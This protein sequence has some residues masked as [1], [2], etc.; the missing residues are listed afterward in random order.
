MN[1]ENLSVRW[2]KAPGSQTQW[3]FQLLCVLLRRPPPGNMENTK[4][5][6]ESIGSIPCRACPGD[7][8]LFTDGQAEQGDIFMVS[9]D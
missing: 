4:G 3:S 2:C 9:R 8:T 1:D 6:Q 5:K 7:T